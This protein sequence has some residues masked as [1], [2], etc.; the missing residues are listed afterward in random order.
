MAKPYD[1]ILETLLANKYLMLPNNSCPFNIPVK[2][3][4]W[5]E[6]HFYNYHKIKGHNMDN[7]FKLKDA[8]QDLID[9]GTILT[10][11]LIKNSDHKV[12][13]THLPKYKKG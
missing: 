8:I 13:K 9:G 12:F 7:F 3:D 4:W 5:K 6:D 11:G 2:P 10:D 1:V